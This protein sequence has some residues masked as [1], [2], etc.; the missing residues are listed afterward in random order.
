MATGA[1]GTALAVQCLGSGKPDRLVLRD[2][3]VRGP[4]TMNGD[5]WLSADAANQV[6]NQM[7]V[8]VYLSGSSPVPWTNSNT[9]TSLEL[10]SAAGASSAVAVSG[11]GADALFGKQ[12]TY[13]A[14]GVG[15]A[16]RVYSVPAITNY[17]GTASIGAL[18][19]D[20]SSVNKSLVIQF[21][22]SINKTITLNQNYTAQS[23]ATIL[24]ALNAALADGT[25]GFYQ[26]SAYTNRARIFQ[27]DREV[28]IENVDSTTITKGMAVSNSV[29]RFKGKVALSSDAATLLVGIA[30]DDIV[31]GA[32]GR[33]LKRGAVIHQDQIAFSGTPSIVFGD[34]FGVS[35]TPGL[36]VE[37]ASVT[38]LR[39]VEVLADG[40]AVLELA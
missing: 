22:G 8:E 17:A 1:V 18:L 40:K 6:A 36:I 31:P 15:F 32:R 23:N 30:L 21:D 5:P 24:T 33:V 13:V 39:A 35:G 29:S 34:V 4:M 25:R 16:A 19:G 9:A 12:P 11:T 3:E 28:E 20:C 38:M 10:R 37:G 14:G 2:T 26:T 7:E 27:L